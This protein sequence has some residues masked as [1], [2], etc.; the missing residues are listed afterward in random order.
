MVQFRHNGRRKSRITGE[1]S[2][3]AAGA[4][5]R[6]SYRLDASSSTLWRNDTP[7][8]LRAKTL[9]VL[10]YLVARPGAV[11]SR[12]ELYRSVWA[13][14]VGNENGPKQCIRELRLLFEDA[15]DGPRFIETVGR[16]G[17]RF[18]G[19]IAVTGDRAAGAQ[20]LQLSPLCVGREAELE[21]LASGLGAARRNARSVC[22]IGGEPGAGKTR[23]IDTFVAR[24]PDRRDFWTA[25]G[26]CMPLHG[27]HEPY[28]PLLDALGSLAGSPA[29]SMLRDLVREI[30]PSWLVHLPDL[31]PTSEVARRQT[32]LVGSAPERMLRELTGVM[33]RLTQRMPGVLVLEDLHWAD[34]STLAW[35]GAWS[36]RRSPARL[37]VIGTYRFD[38]ADRHD[39]PLSATFRELARNPQCCALELGG[40][41]P[42]AIANYFALRFPGHS[43]PPALAAELARRTEGLAILAEAVVDEWVSQGR[44][45]AAGHGWTLDVGVPELVA[46]APSSVQDFIAHQLSRLDAQERRLL[47]AASAVGLTFAAA[48]LPEGDVEVEVVE[49]RCEAL[50]RRRL[51]IEAAGST[52]WPDGTVASVYAFRHA[53]YRD[54]L[55]EGIP[56]GTRRAW[57]RRIGLRMETAYGERTGEIAPFL[58][59]QFESALERPKAAAYRQLSGELALKRGA[60]RDAATHLRLAL[61]HNRSRPE[62][63]DRAEAELRML[64]SFGAALTGS[65][66]FAAPDLPALYDRADEISRDLSDPFTLI[67]LLYGL[68][69]YHLTRADFA[70]AIP[71]ATRLGVLADEGTTDDALTMA[72]HNARSITHWFIG[73]PERAVPHIDAVL[74]LYR[75]DRHGD[76]SALFGEDPG[77]VCRQCAAI[78]YMLIDRPDVAELH[79]QAGMEIADTLRQ[80]FGRTQTLWGGAVIAHG[81][82]DVAAVRDRAE[83]LIETC[84]AADTAFWLPGGQI[85]AGWA[86]V[87]GGDPAGL[88]LIRRGMATWREKQIKLTRPYSLT[89]LAQ[90]CHSCG[91]AAEALAALSEAHRLAQV[92][93]ER[94]PAKKIDRLMKSLG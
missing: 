19:E 65:E 86:A 42:D 88:F 77:I 82:G 62:G 45:R 83:G 1:F 50:S 60:A 85:L 64:V 32:E 73:E 2:Q 28:G 72:A 76:L 38:E 55:Y 68:W 89:V 27:L 18:I 58:A 35:L 23:L 48:A 29:E 7:F 79:F 39:S 61:D 44:V 3:R 22:I 46:Y 5:I 40:L 9:A 49:A 75:V 36:L 13:T 91:M 63:R 81:R 24:L 26:Q 43:F 90:A 93:G 16:L 8:A 20:D 37:F 21:A 33:E 53:L 47:E 34:T 69:N 14:R 51:F 12:E 87:E 56:A 11:V 10:E 4:E 92:T 84:E 25:R 78:V 41:N 94:W 31:F 17:Y 15:V 57:H 54:A 71:L 80:P 52:R 74:A 6:A 30:A 59:D 67:P 66:G 70:R